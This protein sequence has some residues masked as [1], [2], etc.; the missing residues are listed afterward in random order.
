MN[1][2]LCGLY[3]VGLDADAIETIE[4]VGILEAIV[5]IS[6]IYLIIGLYS[7]RC[8]GRCNLQRPQYSIGKIWPLKSCRMLWL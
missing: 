7:Q 5:K 2:D 4:S 1:V 6:S 8:F 3:V